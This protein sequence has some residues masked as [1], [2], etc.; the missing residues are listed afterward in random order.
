MSSARDANDT[1]ISIDISEYIDRFNSGADVKFFNKS[2]NITK[3]IL[4]DEASNNFK[5]V[6]KDIY[7]KLNKPTLEFALNIR[8][9]PGATLEG[10]YPYLNFTTEIQLIDYDVVSDE[11]PDDVIVARFSISTSFFTVPFQDVCGCAQ[12]PRFMIPPNMNIFVEESYRGKQVPRLLIS[13]LVFLLEKLFPNTFSD[14]SYLYI[15]ADGSTIVKEGVKP[16][17]FWDN[18]GMESNEDDVIED[19]S[20]GYEKRIQVCKLKNDY[21]FKNN[22]QANSASAP[23]CV[24]AQ[25]KSCKRKQSAS[26]GDSSSGCGYNLRQRKE[27]GGSKK[28]RKKSKRRSRKSIKRKRNISLKKRR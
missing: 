20:N 28:T 7:Q 15:D 22:N 26:T 12:I 5:P 3:L 23:Q 10:E 13:G 14:S 4:G 17:T 8:L 2:Y 21:L 19:L 6:I 27:K 11:D 25:P 24:V 16:I 18:I 1:Q 9:N